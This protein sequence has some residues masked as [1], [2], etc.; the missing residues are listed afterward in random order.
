M[1]TLTALY[2][3][4]DFDKLPKSIKG[5]RDLFADKDNWYIKCSNAATKKYYE[6]RYGVK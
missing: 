1:N 2:A 4:V 6:F 5:Q 3:I